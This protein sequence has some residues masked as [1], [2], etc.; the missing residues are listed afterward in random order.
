MRSW[1]ESVDSFE[2]WAERFEDNYATRRLCGCLGAPSVAE[3]GSRDAAA[4]AS[5]ARPGG[6]AAS[7]ALDAWIAE[8]PMNA[9]H[10]AC[11]IAR[12]ERMSLV[13]VTEQL[14]DPR[15]PSLLRRRFGWRVP[16]ATPAAAA[17]GRRHA[18]RRFAPRGGRGIRALFAR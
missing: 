9:S 18:P 3:C 2:A 15:L 10:G 8:N 14:D 12:L 7:A 4:N 16:E 5:G 11:A 13:L 1:H 6:L 17:A